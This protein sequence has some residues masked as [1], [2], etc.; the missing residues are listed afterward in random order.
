MLGPSNMNHIDET[1]E[2]TDSR[3]SDAKLGDEEIHYKA[4]G[5]IP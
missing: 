5:G 1:S 2:D 3:S 4:I